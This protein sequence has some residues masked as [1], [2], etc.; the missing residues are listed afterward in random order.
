MPVDYQKMKTNE[1]RRSLDI[2]EIYTMFDHT[3]MHTYTTYEEEHD[4]WEFLYVDEGTLYVETC[5]KV[6]EVCEGACILHR[7]NDAHRHFVLNNSA[8]IYVMSF[9]CHHESLY[10][11]SQK[12]L[13]ANGFVRQMVRTIFSTIHLV[14][15]RYK[16][17]EG[18]EKKETTTP[19]KEEFIRN[20]LEATLLFFLIEE[21]GER[22]P[23]TMWEEA[24]DDIVKNIIQ[25][26]KE[27]VEENICV[28]A[29]AEQFHLCRSTLSIRFK[30]ETGR[31]IMDYFAHLKVTRSME[32]LK[33]E[34]M[35]IS[36]ISE[37][38]DYSS[39]QYFG[40]IFKKYT[41]L[42]PTAYREKMIRNV[43]GVKRT[44]KKKE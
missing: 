20:C 10:V 12:Q 25:Y 38:L 39:V 32:L 7:P 37:Q 44:L 35:S 15:E 26:M 36:A 23:G 22:V 8:H 41:G 14:F 31:S 13:N 29:L 33:N 4:F 3:L 28:D 9:K 2:G 19:L 18:F 16:S 1:L 5:G 6:M 11:I 34:G 21:E 42:T 24:T 30:K 43:D 17:G 27:K 40:K